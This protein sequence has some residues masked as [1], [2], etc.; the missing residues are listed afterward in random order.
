MR[1]ALSVPPHPPD[2][3]A[4]AAA[5]R[6]EALLGELAA[7]SPLITLETAHAAP[8]A[9]LVDDAPVV[10]TL[11]GKTRG[12]VHFAGTPAGYE[13]P[14]LVNAILDVSRGETG[15]SS[16]TVKV[17]EELRNPVSVRMLVSASCSSCAA[18]ARLALQLAIVSSHVDA[19]VLDAAQLPRF[20][21][22]IGG[23][24]MPAA[25]INDI[26]WVPGAQAELAL[27]A[28]VLFAGT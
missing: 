27:L 19:W 9:E 3:A 7:L 12:G 25:L 2:D 23:T 4:Y 14:I 10:V 15:L 8:P 13:V 22:R 11:A 26:C 1:I 17:L 18:D 6:A 20:A 5:R 21:R 16:G 28:R 24:A